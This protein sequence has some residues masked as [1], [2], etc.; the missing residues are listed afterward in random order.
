MQSKR[1]LVSWSITFLE[2]LFSNHYSQTTFLKP[3]FSNHLE[4]WL[5]IKWPTDVTKLKT[6][7]LIIN[8]PDLGF[9]GNLPTLILYNSVT[10][11]DKKRTKRI[12]VAL[13]S[14]K[15]VW[16]AFFLQ[17]W[18]PCGHERLAFRPEPQIKQSNKTNPTG[19]DQKWTKRTS[20]SLGSMKPV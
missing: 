15:P 11:P 9:Q 8:W 1:V 16:N 6:V 19:L 4:K 10:R 7:L 20:L 18:P 14:M 17:F 12:T 13:G 5:Q 2:P 3:L